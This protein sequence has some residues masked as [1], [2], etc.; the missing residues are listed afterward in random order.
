MSSETVELE[1]KLACKICGK[2][3]DPEEG[4]EI[5]DDCQ[6]RRMMLWVV[7]LFLI[8]ICLAGLPW[9]ASRLR[10]QRPKP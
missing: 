5:C 6:S 1:P 8:A 7:G 2:P 4:Q 9:L 3:F 10:T